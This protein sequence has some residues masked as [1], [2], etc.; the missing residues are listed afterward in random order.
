MIG[1]V[2]IFLLCKKSPHKS[3]TCFLCRSWCLPFSVFLRHLSLMLE[4]N[5][6]MFGW[7]GLLIRMKQ[8]RNP[9]HMVGFRES[10]AMSIFYCIEHIIVIISF[11][12]SL[13]THRGVSDSQN[14]VY[15]MVS[16]KL[17]NFIFDQPFISF[18]RGLRY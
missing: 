7:Q 2:H 1:A 15:F 6:E 5:G 8:L 13:Q 17:P 10:F 3:L 9:T 12:S 4:A 18:L 11:I 16:S 14:R